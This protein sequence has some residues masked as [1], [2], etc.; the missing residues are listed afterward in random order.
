MELPAEFIT[1][2]GRCARLL[3]TVI[4]IQLRM[5]VM[6]EYRVVVLVLVI[7]VGIL[8]AGAKAFA[9][10][11]LIRVLGFRIREA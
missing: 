11:Q 4:G 9:R 6:I 2:I 10:E 1:V 3:M 5:G 8:T 7:L